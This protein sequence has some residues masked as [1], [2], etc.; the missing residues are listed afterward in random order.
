[1]VRSARS[2]IGRERSPYDNRRPGPAWTC[3]RARTLARARSGNPRCWLYCLA[4]L[5]CLASF[6]ILACLESFA[7]F[8]SFAIL[9]CLVTR[10]AACLLDEPAGALGEIFFSA[11]PFTS[12]IRSAPEGHAHLMGRVSSFRGGTRGA[13]RHGHWVMLVTVAVVTLVTKEPVTSV[14]FVWGL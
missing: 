1:M 2:A 3:E 11:T 14:T 8:D 4:S 7:C 9:A 6:A 5:V 13:G 10:V 12:S